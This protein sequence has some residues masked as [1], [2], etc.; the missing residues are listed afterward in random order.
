MMYISLD[1]I[2]YFAASI[3]NSSGVFV[4]TLLMEI[5]ILTDEDLSWS[6]CPYNTVLF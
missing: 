3:V 6:L 5:I 2:H 1:N 4:P